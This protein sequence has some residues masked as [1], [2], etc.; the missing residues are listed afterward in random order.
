VPGTILA[1]ALASNPAAS[2]LSPVNDDVHLI[3]NRIILSF[4][5]TMNKVSTWRSMPAFEDISK[6]LESSEQSNETEKHLSPSPL[7]TSHSSD[8]LQKTLE[9]ILN[10]ARIAA[11]EACDVQPVPYNTHSFSSYIFSLRGRNFSMIISPL[12]ALLLWG[13]GWQLLFIFLPKGDSY[14]EKIGSYVSDLQHTLSS[15]DD[16]ISNL[17]TPVSFLLTFRLGRAAIRFWDARQAAG[18]MIEKCRSNIATAAVGFISPIRLKRRYSRKQQQLRDSKK[19]NDEQMDQNDVDMDEA[20]IPAAM[21]AQPGEDFDAEIE[22]LC[23]YARWLTSFPIAVKQFLR[24]EER[25]GWDDTA[26]YKKL[27][28]E[29]GPLLCD[30]D[31]NHI[32]LA[33]DD[34]RGQSTFDRNAKRVREPPL[35]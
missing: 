30:E 13:L 27:R 35:V 31:A 19:T 14:N 16:L 3:R 7:Y 33:Y 8:T 1:T 28:F 24:P 9:D 4:K 2:L 29:I 17:I 5:D 32:I 11:L 23:E 15:V 21:S 10:P 34:E 25:P 6:I 20:T 22:L 26:Y 12:L 18:L